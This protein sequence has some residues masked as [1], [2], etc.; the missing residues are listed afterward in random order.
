MLKHFSNKN[1]FFGILSEDEA[2][3]LITACGKPGCFLVR[4]SSSVACFTLSYLKEYK[5]VKSIQSVRYSPKQSIIIISII[6]AA[7]KKE[8]LT[9]P[10][11][12]SPFQVLFVKQPAL[13]TG[14]FKY[15]PDKKKDKGKDK[16]KDKDKDSNGGV[17][18]GSKS[19][20][21]FIP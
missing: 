4:F 16:D 9:I 18:G 17:G 11:P 10:L 19:N 14:Y 3:K 7:I 15:D 8:K 2:T 13:R 1:G 20:L 21:I 12:Q 5:K 6:R